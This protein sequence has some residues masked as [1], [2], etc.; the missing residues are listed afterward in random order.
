LPKVYARYLVSEV[1]LNCRR[2][3]LIQEEFSVA[4]VIVGSKEKPPIDNVFLHRKGY[5]LLPP[6]S[7]L[8]HSGNFLLRFRPF[9]SS[10]QNETSAELGALMPSILDKAFRGEL[11]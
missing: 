4:E 2:K 8:G 10:R 9:Q 1:V 3:Q 7:I 5:D 11:L 6:I